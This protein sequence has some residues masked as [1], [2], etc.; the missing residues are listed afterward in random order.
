[1]EHTVTIGADH[2]DVRKAGFTAISTQ[3]AYRD[4]MVSFDVTQ[5][6][7]SILLRKI[8][9]AANALQGALQSESQFFCLSNQFCIPLTLKVE[10]FLQSAFG[11]DIP[12]WRTFLGKFIRLAPACGEQEKI[13]K[14]IPALA[15][16]TRNRNHN[17]NGLKRFHEI[18]ASCFVPPISLGWAVTPVKTEL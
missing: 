8:E 13:I 1:M 11:K 5:P 6:P 3:L 9:V 7:F 18:S 4:R 16:I 15:H 17:I 12:D 10:L 14:K 2:R